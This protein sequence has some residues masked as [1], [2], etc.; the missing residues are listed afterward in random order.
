MKSDITLILSSVSILFTGITAFFS[1]LAYSKVV[2]LENS[3]HKVQYV[4]M[5]YMGESSTFNGVPLDDI[6][7]G[8][9]LEKQ[10]E[11]AFGYKDLEESQ[12]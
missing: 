3:T 2:G 6:K 11:K 9:P 12:I 8:E 1:I 4:P 10:M 5:D 7:E